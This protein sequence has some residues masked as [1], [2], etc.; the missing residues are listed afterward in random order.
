MLKPSIGINAGII[1]QH[2]SK[3]GIL[4]I[5]ELGQLTNLKSTYL[6]FSLGWL[7]REN[8]IVITEKD[9]AIYVE[10]VQNAPDI[11]Y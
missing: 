1:W 8:K 11:Y 3:K 9:D 2:L 7:A 4:T 10:L 6:T 5:R